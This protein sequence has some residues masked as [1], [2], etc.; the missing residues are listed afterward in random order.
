LKRIDE[1]IDEK[2]RKEQTGFRKGRRKNI[3]TPNMCPP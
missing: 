3:N 2:L 1:K